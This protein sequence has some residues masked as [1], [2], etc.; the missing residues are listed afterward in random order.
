[1]IEHCHG[2]CRK[3][4]VRAV[5]LEPCCVSHFHDGSESRW[6]TPKPHWQTC[7]HKTIVN[8]LDVIVE[9]RGCHRCNKSEKQ[10]GYQA[11]QLRHELG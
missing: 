9:H 1:M 11:W 7:R 6:E 4:R 3:C 5:P 10:I 8:A 2:D